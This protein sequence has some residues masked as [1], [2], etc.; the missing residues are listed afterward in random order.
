[1]NPSLEQTGL[2]E[3]PLPPAVFDH[4]VNN[5]SARSHL[6]FNPHLARD[7]WIRLW[8]PK[9]PADEACHLC[10]H[11]LDAEQIDLVLASERRS[12]VVGNVFACSKPDA[13]QQRRAL[14]RVSGKDF[15]VRVLSAPGFDASNFELAASKLPGPGRLTYLVHAGTAE[16]VVAALVGIEELWGTSPRHLIRKRNQAVT[17]ALHNI[18]GVFAGVMA[19][20]RVAGSVPE[21]LRSPLAGCRLLTDASDQHLVLGLTPDAT[22]GAGADEY[23]ALAL[24][25]N[26][27]ADTTLVDKL[28]RHPSYRVRDAVSRRLNTGAVPIT[29]PY[30]SIAEVSQLVWALRRSLP[31]NYRPDGRLVDLV[32]LA[33]NPLV[34]ADNATRVYQGL[35]DAYHSG[36]ALDA[37]SAESFNAAVAALAAREPSCEP[38][39]V[40]EPSIHERLSETY[41]SY[42]QR[43]CLVPAPAADHEPS[44]DT[45][46]RHRR[47]N[48]EQATYW[49][50]AQTFELLNTEF[51]DSPAK[52]EL[53]FN[54]AKT[55]RG[56][57][58][59]LCEAV[60]RMAR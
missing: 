19:A 20:A 1:V 26:P 37:V 3:F 28:R 59:Q 15:P 42:A 45:L 48:T 11:V 25:A 10:L 34:V 17:Y 44:L 39:S 36:R 40:S 2:R 52:W 18:D 21:P 47:I 4:F 6:R 38:V 50:A 51:G 35:I 56:T 60:N 13:A 27:V 7:H 49:S 16:A 12:G 33:H 46:E 23:P 24:A 58:G 41:Y 22:D 29:T 9:L 53:A 31:N 43:R 57:L 30:E 5:K 32:A 8:E 55:H 14:E 54:L